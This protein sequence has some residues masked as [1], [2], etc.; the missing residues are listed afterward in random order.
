MGSKCNQSILEK[1]FIRLFQKKYWSHTI[2]KSESM[3][4]QLDLFF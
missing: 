4:I 1:Y 2:V 3:A